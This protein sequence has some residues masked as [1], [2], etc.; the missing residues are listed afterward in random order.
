MEIGISP[1]YGI[2]D[3]LLYTPAIRVLKEY[4]PD[5][6]ITAFTFFK[7]TRDVLIGNPYIDEIVYFPMLNKS[8]IKTLLFLRKYMKKF[9]V[10]INFY[11]SNR[12]EYNLFAL[13]LMPKNIIGHKYLKNS[14]LDMNFVKSWKIQEDYSLHVVEENLNLLKYFDINSP[15][16]YPLQFFLKEEEREK[17]RKIITKYNSKL[18]IGIHAGTST[19]KNHD[20]RRWPIEYFVEFATMLKDYNNDTILFVFGG[21]EEAHIKR[22]IKEKLENIMEVIKVDTESIRE[23]GAVMSFMDIFVSNDSGLMHL[24]AALGLP[25]IGIF[26]PT[27]P[28]WVKPWQTLNKVVRLGLPCSPC[29]YYSPKPLTCPKGLNFKCLRKLSPNM[30]FKAFK[31]LLEEIKKGGIKLNI[32]RKRQKEGD[33]I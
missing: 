29:F 27:N 25:T 18:K 11:P 24:S 3:T 31:E 30:V 15:P 17:A 26:G 33:L 10:V 6:R 4:R 1:L 8:K 7:T 23:T 9:N 14:I 5:Y 13:S 20:K 2:G 19:F 22:F 12:R 21:P 32:Q 28:V 16:R